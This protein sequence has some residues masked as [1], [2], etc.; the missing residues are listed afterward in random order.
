M[1]HL[2]LFPFRYRDPIT[3]K[4]VRAGYRAERHEIAARYAEWEITGRRRSATLTRT[5][6]R[7]VRM[8]GR[9]SAT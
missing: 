8:G 3:G 7:S 1:P 2:E 4:W 9:S 6:E 5:R